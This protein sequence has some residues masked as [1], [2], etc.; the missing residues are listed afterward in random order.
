MMRSSPFRDRVDAGGHLADLLLDHA[1][2]ADVIVLALPRGGVPV[3]GVVAQRLGAPLDALVVRKVGMPGHEELALGA[4]GPDVTLLDHRLIAQVGL[5]PEALEPTVV[6][7]QAERER[8]EAVYRR[9]RA[10]L[11]ARGRTV[12]LV[13]DGLATGATMVVAVSAARGLLASSVLV[14]VPVAPAS[15]ICRLAGVADQVVTVAR[16]SPFS[17]VG[18]WYEDFSPVSDAEV[19]RWLEE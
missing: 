12:I 5:T 19:C 7:E 1:G 13:D 17:A 18:E 11:D 2:R 9:G 8:R 4:V 14:A 15:A 6:R 10:P 16:P 3:G